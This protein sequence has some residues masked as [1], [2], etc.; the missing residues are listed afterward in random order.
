MIE[1]FLNVLLGLFHLISLLFATFDFFFVLKIK[2][3]VLTHNLL[4]LVII[5]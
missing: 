3:K 1:L 5:H 2:R 4:V